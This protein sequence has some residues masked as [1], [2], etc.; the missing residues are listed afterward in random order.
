[1]RRRL[2]AAP[3]RV[4]LFPFLSVL[5]CAVGTLVVV[6]AG[7]ALSG[8]ES[9]AQTF[10]VSVREARGRAP[11]REWERQPIY[12]LC[13]RGGLVV[14]RSADDVRRLPA[15]SLDGGEAELLRLADSMERL[16]E[17]RWPVLL[18]KPSGLPYCTRL[19][20]HL[21]ARRVRVGKWA[22]AEAATIVCEATGP[23]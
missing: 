9:S 18:I 23:R 8:L 19:Y 3:A 7:V 4:P 15:A 21:A 6:F 5:L 1:V 20:D 12:V 10:V 11:G 17:Q 16:R 22:F 13:D 14:Y 2:S